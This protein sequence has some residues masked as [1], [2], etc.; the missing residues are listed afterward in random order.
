MGKKDGTVKTTLRI[1]DD[2]LR[3]AKIYGINHD[4]S[5]QAVI[6]LALERLLA[7][8]VRA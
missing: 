6:A 8:E 2:L 1:S 4:L 3:R 5:V 7:R